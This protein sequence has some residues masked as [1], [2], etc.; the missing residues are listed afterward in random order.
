[1]TAI[2]DPV[3]D[4]RLGP[5]LGS[6]NRFRLA[7]FGFNFRA[8]LVMSFYEG[9]PQA[10]WE[11]SLRTAIAADRMGLEALIPLARWQPYSAA[12]TG[13]RGFEPFTWAAGLASVTERIGVFA[14]FLIPTVHPV[15]GAKMAATID[16][17]SGGRFG[18]NIVSGW[19]PAEIGMFGA[20]YYEHDER[21][22]VSDEWIELVK[23][24]WTEETPFDFEGRFFNA[25]GAVSEPKPLQQPY[26]LL[27][28]AGI[29]PAGRAFAAKHTDLVFAVVEEEEQR[30]RTVQDLKRLAREEH[31]KE[32]L[33]FT[34]GNVICRDTEEE[35]RELYDRVY[36]TEGD[37]EAGRNVLQTLMGN[38]QTIDWDAFETRRLLESTIRGFFA[39]P[40]VGTPEQ[41]VGEMV[42]LSEAGFDGLAISLPDHDDGLERLEH[43][44]LP[45]LVD[46]GLRVPV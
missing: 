29:S 9:V 34:H 22:D 17:I 35:A 13:G 23:R 6:P 46:A 21:Y 36:K 18:L 30:V 41:V 20:Q 4:K 2:P 26:P 8:G 5:V 37:W 1:M 12:G 39:Y 15:L 42:R 31:G 32:I 28:S 45:L 25:P 19:Q 40:L 27:M 38:S 24:L 11:Q 33:V 7:L 3:L 43:Q 14:T 44:I 16:H 10:T